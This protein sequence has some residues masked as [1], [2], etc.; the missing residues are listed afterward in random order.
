MQNFT[1]RGLFG[2]LALVASLGAV[3]LPAFADEVIITREP[4]PPRAEVIPVLPPGRAELE[5]WQPGH[6]RWDGH[7]H[8]WVE[9]RYVARPQR[10][11]EWVPAHYDRRPG[12]WVFIEGHWR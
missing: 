12:G 7:E 2:S 9:G 11:A 6:W 10:G 5:V 1:R 4:P 3:T 8:V